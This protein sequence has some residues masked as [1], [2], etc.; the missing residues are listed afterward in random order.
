M[1]TGAIYI[2]ANMCKAVAVQK[3]A[4]DSGFVRQQ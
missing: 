3:G 4:V 2:F 1:F